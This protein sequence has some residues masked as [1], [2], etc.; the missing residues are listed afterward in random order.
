MLSKAWQPSLRSGLVRL[1]ELRHT[2]QG[3]KEPACESGIRKKGKK[4]PSMLGELSKPSFVYINITVHMHV[5][6]VMVI[7]IGIAL[8]SI[9]N[10]GFL[11]ISDLGTGILGITN[12]NLEVSGLKL[13]ISGIPNLNLE[14]LGFLSQIRG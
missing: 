11:G 10:L 5:I 1:L 14:V 13:G 8:G 7:M 6:I 2:K 12:L 9:L 4:L 3:N